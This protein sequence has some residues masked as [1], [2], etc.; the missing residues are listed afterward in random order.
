MLLF[1][2]AGGR[3][4]Q[5]EVEPLAD[6][7]GPPWAGRSPYPL[8]QFGEQL[9]RNL[10]S[11]D[12]PEGIKRLAPRWRFVPSLPLVRVRCLAIAGLWRS[13]AGRSLL[14]FDPGSWIIRV[15]MDIRPN[16]RLSSRTAS[17]VPSLPW[18][19]ASRG[20]GYAR[21]ARAGMPLLRP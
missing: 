19:V 12:A 10:I 3:I 9:S 20:S 7:V 11:L 15:C 14:G 2:G 1:Q 16:A 13:C 17:S 5:Q 6:A 8:L 4:P 18:P 21:I